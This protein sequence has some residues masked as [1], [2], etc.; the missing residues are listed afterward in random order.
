MNTVFKPQDIPKRN[1]H[2]YSTVR[3]VFLMHNQT[4]V[5]FL[6]Y[7]FALSM[8]LNSFFVGNSIAQVG[9]GSVIATGGS[10]YT[11]DPVHVD[12]VDF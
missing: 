9:D 2:H 8:C 12:G 3:E 1:V 5:S 4:K 11:I 6:F 10:N 7:I